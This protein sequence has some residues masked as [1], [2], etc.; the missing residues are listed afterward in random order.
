VLTEGSLH[1]SG[2]GEQMKRQASDFET[3][4]RLG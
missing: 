2:S 3:E 4:T 1:S